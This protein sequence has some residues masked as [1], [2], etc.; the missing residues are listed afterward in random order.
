[1]NICEQFEKSLAFFDA[2]WRQNG[3]HMKQLRDYEI[4]GFTPIQDKLLPKTIYYRY[5]E[6]SIFPDKSVLIGTKDDGFIQVTHDQFTN[7]IQNL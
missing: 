1:M 6:H 3:W 5:L 2:C 4:D 7:F